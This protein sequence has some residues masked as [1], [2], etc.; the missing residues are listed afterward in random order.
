M[1]IKDL[2]IKSKEKIHKNG[3]QYYHV[4][5]DSIMFSGVIALHPIHISPKSIRN[6]PFLFSHYFAIDRLHITQDRSGKNLRIRLDVIFS[7]FVWI[8]FFYFT[9]YSAQCAHSH[10]RG[11]RNWMVIWKSE[12]FMKPIRSHPFMETLNWWQQFSSFRE[13]F[14]FLFGFATI[15][16]LLSLY[17]S[18][19][20][21]IQWNGTLN[22]GKM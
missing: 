14:E 13:Q 6:H 17:F 2:I 1:R 8:F 15:W 18:F 12:N 22:K 4:T 19:V 10:V 20:N 3:K 11:F 21:V 5:V 9:V 16:C 7:C